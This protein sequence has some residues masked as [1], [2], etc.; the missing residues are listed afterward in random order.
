MVPNDD[1]SEIEEV[2]AGQGQAVA[3]APATAPAIP[4]ASPSTNRDYIEQEDIKQFIRRGLGSVI[5]GDLDNSQ[6]NSQI[7]YFKKYKS[8]NQG[9]STETTVFLI[10]VEVDKI[11]KLFN[12]QNQLSRFKFDDQAKF[13]LVNHNHALLFNSIIPQSFV[14]ITDNKKIEDRIFDIE[15]GS[16]FNQSQKYIYL[17]IDES[18]QGDN[19]DDTV[20]VYRKFKVLSNGGSNVDRVTG[21]KA[22]GF[23][24]FKEGNLSTIEE[25]QIQKEFQGVASRDI[26]FNFS[27]R[28][29]SREEYIGE[30]S[31]S[32]KIIKIN[33]NNKDL[34]EDQELK[35]KERDWFQIH[36]PIDLNN[37]PIFNKIKINDKEVKIQIDN[38]GKLQIEFPDNSKTKFS[39]GGYL[40]GHHY[41]KVVVNINNTDY[42]LS[43]GGINFNSNNEETNKEQ[44]KGI[45]L[46]LQKDNNNREP[47][48]YECEIDLQTNE[49]RL[50]NACKRS[51]EPPQRVLSDSNEYELYSC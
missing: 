14:K 2:G 10:G 5:S 18:K 33:L 19:P 8:I 6:G 16:I 9:D 40:Y 32:N 45:R 27:I 3:P 23:A 35:G 44:F 21:I 46:T 38:E 24:L 30:A 28:Q 42:S 25:S 12:E 4:S 17:P 22:V 39:S 26:K 48:S 1:F 36:D 20:V 34:K 37:N 50:L 15:I 11:K 13:N 7:L 43:K 49:I 47:M 31:R 51:E 41:N 29:D